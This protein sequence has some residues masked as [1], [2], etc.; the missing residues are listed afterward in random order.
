M[1][2]LRFFSSGGNTQRRGHGQYLDI[3]PDRRTVDNQ[4]ETVNAVLEERARRSL[5]AQCERA[6]LGWESAAA[7]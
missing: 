7:A 5:Y 4:V 1:A 3:A 6:P 2:A